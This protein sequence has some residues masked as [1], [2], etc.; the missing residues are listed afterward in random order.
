VEAGR[1]CRGP[2]RIWP[3][4]GGGGGGTGRAPVRKGGWIGALPPVDKGG[5]KGAGLP[6]GS[7]GIVTEAPSLGGEGAASGTGE[8]AALAA[9]AGCSGTCAGAW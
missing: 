5:R 7:S 6:R 4:R 3:G 2:D 9:I 8:G 1:G